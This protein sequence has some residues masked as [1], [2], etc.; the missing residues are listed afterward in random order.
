MFQALNCGQRSEVKRII[1][2]AAEAR[3]RNFTQEQLDTATVEQAL[4]HPTWHMGRKITVDSATMMNKALEIIEARWLFD[5][6]PEQI[7]VVVHPQSVV[8]SL[9]EFCDGSVVAQL[10]PPDMR[11]PIQYAL[12][13]PERNLRPAKRLDFSQAFRLDFEP[14]DAAAVSGLT[15]GRGGGPPGRHGGRGAECRKRSGRGFV[16]EPTDSFTQIAAACRAV[17]DVTSL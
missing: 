2:T 11:L 15:I 1:L 13:W 16:F 10:S 5:L 12:T 17:V 9:V 4:A 6:R 7:E 8:H 3:F 14:P